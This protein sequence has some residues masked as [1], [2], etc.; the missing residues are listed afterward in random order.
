MV[1][2]VVVGLV[3]RVMDEKGSCGRVEWEGLLKPPPP[4]ENLACVFFIAS[5][6]DIDIL[7]PSNSRVCL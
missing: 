2:V 6:L 4:L 7:W 3:V 1:V 5:W